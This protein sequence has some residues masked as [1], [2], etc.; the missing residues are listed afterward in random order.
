MTPSNQTTIEQG[1]R[2]LAAGCPFVNLHMQ[3]A[4]HKIVPD[5][6][7]LGRLWDIAHKLELEYEF[8]LELTSAELTEALVA[9][10]ENYYRAEKNT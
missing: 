8:P 2:L 3:P 1:R 6:I 4:N 9:A 10:L 7:P 5:P